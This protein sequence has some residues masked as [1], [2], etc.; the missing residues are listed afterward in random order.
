MAATIL[1]V[2]DL[3]IG[4]FFNDKTQAE[5]Y[6]KYYETLYSIVKP[7]MFKLILEAWAIITRG[8]PMELTVPKDVPIKKDVM[9]LIKKQNSINKLGLIYF[10]E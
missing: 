8:I 4:T 2:I 9:A 7:T 5:A 3:V 10:K 6:E 1:K